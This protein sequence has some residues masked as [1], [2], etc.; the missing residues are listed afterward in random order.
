MGRVLALNAYNPVSFACI[1]QMTIE[2]FQDHQSIAN[3]D[4][5]IIGYAVLLKP[6]VRHNNYA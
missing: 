5:I 6:G 1:L 4:I 2:A 3:N